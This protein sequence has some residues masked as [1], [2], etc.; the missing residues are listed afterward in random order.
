M[1]RTN[2]KGPT[3]YDRVVKMIENEEKCGVLLFY[4]RH[5]TILEQGPIEI[6]GGV[7]DIASS[8]DA[9]ELQVHFIKSDKLHSFFSVDLTK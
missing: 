1:I 3:D 2:G 4:L 8:L 6:F 7:P 9:D 5:G